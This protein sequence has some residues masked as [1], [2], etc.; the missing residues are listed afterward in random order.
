MEVWIILKNEDKK[1]KKNMEEKDN[2]TEI[3]LKKCVNFSK[4]HQR[5]YKIQTPKEGDEFY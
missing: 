2:F 1:E 3:S 5:K 4:V